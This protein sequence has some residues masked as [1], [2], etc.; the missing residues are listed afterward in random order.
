MGSVYGAEADR[1]AKLK[2][3]NLNSTIPVWGSITEIQGNKKSALPH[4][5]IEDL[6]RGITINPCT[7]YQYYV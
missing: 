1:K 3:Y 2:T 5:S 4:K 7:F 6:Q